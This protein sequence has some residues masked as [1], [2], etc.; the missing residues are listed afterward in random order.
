VDKATSRLSVAKKGLE[1]VQRQL[2]EKTVALH[3]AGP[4]LATDSIAVS[5]SFLTILLY[6]EAE[7]HRIEKVLYSK[8]RVNLLLDVLEK[9]EHIRLQRVQ[10]VE[11]LLDELKCVLFF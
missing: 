4:F 5:E 7:L 6:A 1:F 10:H 11:K 9:K 2:D 8:R 3:N